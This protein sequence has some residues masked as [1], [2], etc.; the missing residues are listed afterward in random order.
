MNSKP[1]SIIESV[2]ILLPLIFLIEHSA[3]VS[4]LKEMLNPQQK[5]VFCHKIIGTT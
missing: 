4:E 5:D 2:S 1:L 3:R